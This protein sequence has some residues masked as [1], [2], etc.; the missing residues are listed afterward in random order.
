MKQFIQGTIEREEV[1]T[2]VMKNM[3]Y[4]SWFSETTEEANT[5]SKIFK[6]LKT[7]KTR[8]EEEQFPGF[9]NLVCEQCGMVTRSRTNDVVVCSSCGNDCLPAVV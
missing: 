8:P 9:C 6:E 1:F 2:A 5:V 7:L 4:L 3:N